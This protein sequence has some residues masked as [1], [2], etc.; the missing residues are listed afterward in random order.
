MNS[1]HFR[2]I[3]SAL[4]AD[5]DIAN[6]PTAMANMKADEMR[7]HNEFF[8]YAEDVGF[9]ADQIDFLYRWINP[10]KK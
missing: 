10:L 8:R 1:N 7:L 4:V 6:N 9:T 5:N 3:Q 2:E